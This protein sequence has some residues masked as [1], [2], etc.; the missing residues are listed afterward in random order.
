MS[1]AFIPSERF[2]KGFEKIK[3]IGG[4]TGEN[5]IAGAIESLK[6]I[7][8]E[9][10]QYTVEYPFGDICSRPQLDIRSREIATIAALIALGFAIP[11]LKIHINVGL[12]VGLS[13]SEIKEII[14]QMSVY[15]GFPAALNAMN[16]AKEVFNARKV[17][18]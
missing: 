8:P 4:K 14:I 5:A 10:A 16:A 13:E 1:D 12:N 15:V 7:S 9:L 3:E 6:E 18:T 2:K 11:Q 17:K